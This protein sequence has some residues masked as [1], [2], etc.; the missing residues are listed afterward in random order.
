MYDVHWVSTQDRVSILTKYGNQMCINN[1]LNGNQ[2]EKALDAEVLFQ[3]T[4]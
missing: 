3:W 4:Q 1:Q 2:V